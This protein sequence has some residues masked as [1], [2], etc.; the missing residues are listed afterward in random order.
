MTAV[1]DILASLPIDQLAEQVGADPA[2]VQRAVTA[3]VPALLG[4]LGANAQD[5]GADSLLSALGQHDNGLLTGGVNLDDVDTTDGSRIAGH[6]FGSQEDAVVSQLGGLQAASSGGSLGGDLVK[7]LIPI[8]APIV[9][10]YLAGKIFGGK[11]STSTSGGPVSVP[12]GGGALPTPSGSGGG[13]AGGPGSL[14]DMLQDVLGSAIGGATGSGSAPTTGTSTDAGS[15]S[16]GGVNAGS[17]I[18][19]ILG[20]LLGGGRR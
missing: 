13:Q 8:L 11:G 6:I 14:Q 20:G 7:K 5:G 3:A 10:S 18:T 15:S 16:T 1:D 2:D 19:D 17:I 4:G 9:L 12:S